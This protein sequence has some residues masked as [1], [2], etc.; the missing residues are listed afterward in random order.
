MDGLLTFRSAEPPVSP[1]PEHDSGRSDGCAWPKAPTQPS[2]IQEQQQQAPEG[3]SPVDAANISQIY[4]L[5]SSEVYQY[6]QYRSFTKKLWF[7]RASVPEELERQ[8]SKPDGVKQRLDVDLQPTRDEI[9]RQ[10]SKRGRALPERQFN[11]ELRMTG[12]TT[13]PAFPQADTVT[14]RPRIW[15]L[16]GSDWVLKMVRKAIKNLGWI[17]KFLR[18]SVGYCI[19]GPQLCTKPSTIPL[20]VLNCD[21]GLGCSLN[22]RDGRIMYHIARLDPRHSSASVCGWLCCATYVKGGEVLEQRV[23][24]IG[25]ALTFEML[26]SSLSQYEGV[27]LTA[28]HGVLGGAGLEEGAGLEGVSGSDTT[29]DWSDESD[30]DD[31]DNDDDDDE[32]LD[33]DIVSHRDEG[34]WIEK[35]TS[36]SK[37][38]AVEESQVRP[39]DT[40]GTVDLTAVMGWIPF[41]EVR[42]VNLLGNL[43]G[44]ARMG[45]LPGPTTAQV[46]DYALLH[47][48]TVRLLHN[49]Y[50]APNSDEPPL[51]TIK[52]FMKD[53]ALRPG[54]IWLVLGMEDVEEA[55]LLP[56]KTEMTLGDRILRVRKIQL[57]AP[58]GLFR[59][60]HIFIALTTWP[61]T[62]AH[63]PRDLRYVVG[64]GRLLVRHDRGQLRVGTV[65]TFYSR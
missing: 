33:E 59:S 61:L 55:Q 25:G 30:T 8:W 29:R 65:G 36:I 27:V 48:D 15:V 19:G 13:V 46:S 9:Q 10:G 31:D 22:Y 4:P 44:T 12:Y 37:G 57:K 3:V 24:R 16:C 43:L 52:Y 5:D 39:I 26:G 23:S 2:Q 18:R 7:G 40:I 42:A 35:T 63:S 11:A 58:L 28:A 38:K 34:S 53:E 64:S 49:S 62:Y 51:R 60:I 50:V 45:P 32:Y 56:G 20:D 41:E 47:S 17:D 1:N 21:A 14:L 54:R 6:H